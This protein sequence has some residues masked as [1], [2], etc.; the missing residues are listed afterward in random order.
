MNRVL[1]PISAAIFCLAAAAIFL[2]FLASNQSAKSPASTNSSNS[3]ARGNEKSTAD[4]VEEIRSKIALIEHEIRERQQRLSAFR[5]MPWLNIDAP[6]ASPNDREEQ[7]A[8]REEYE[9]DTR[10]I[11]QLEDQLIQFRGEITTLLMMED[12]HRRKEA[13]GN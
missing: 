4:R 12:W 1:R 8:L 2:S 10:Q 3:P 5:K 11:R 13:Y 9:S 7:Q 6:A